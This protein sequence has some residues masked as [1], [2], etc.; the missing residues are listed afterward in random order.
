MRVEIDRLLTDRPTDKLIESALELSKKQK[1]YRVLRRK[2]FDATVPQEGPLKTT[3]PMLPS[4]SATMA[5]ML[6]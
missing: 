4:R 3:A 1:S 2:V 6:F 5:G